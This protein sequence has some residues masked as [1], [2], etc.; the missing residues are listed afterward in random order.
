MYANITILDN[1]F[2]AFYDSTGVGDHNV[3][4]LFNKD[5]EPSGYKNV[6]EEFR[7]TWEAEEDY[8]MIRKKKGVSII[9]FRPPDDVLLFLRD[10]KPDIPCPGKWDILGGNVEVGETPV[11]CIVREITEEIEVN[12]DTPT[13]FN[14]CDF[15]DR[16]EYTYWQRTTFSIDEVPLHEG[17]ELRWFSEKDVRS[18][19]EDKIAFDF[20]TVLLDFFA[21]R[22]YVDKS[23]S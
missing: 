12:L 13:L 1:A 8:G 3:S 4:L 20:K 6:E 23:S 11:Q 22:P 10:N 9:F 21:R 18:L 7:R 17:Q 14:V 19:P 2:M 16:L 15:D 5:S